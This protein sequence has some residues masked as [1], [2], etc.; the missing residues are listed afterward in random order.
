MTGIPPTPLTSG[1]PSI[2][3]DSSS[4]VPIAVQR[5]LQLR[6]GSTQNFSRTPIGPNSLVLLDSKITQRRLQLQRG[7]IQTIL[8]ALFSS[9]RVHR[10]PIRAFDLLM[11][12]LIRT[13]L[14]VVESPKDS[15]SLS[16]DLAIGIDA[17]ATGFS[18]PCP[19]VVIRVSFHA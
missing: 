9:A 4:I 16:F 12:S 15:L 5:R 18:R 7:S 17:G 2:P 13:F 3:P 14:D 19:Q 11:R 6:C 10:S 1:Q 8:R